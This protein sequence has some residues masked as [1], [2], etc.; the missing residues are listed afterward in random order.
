MKKIVVKKSV[1]EFVEFILKYGSLDNRFS[2]NARAIEGV[3]AHQKLQKSNLEIYKDYEKEVYLK[4]EIEMDVCSI[5]IEG[6]AD[7]IIVEGNETIIE[8]IKST[9]TPLIEIDEDYNPIHWAQGKVYA[10]MVAKDKKLETI[11][12]QL[13]YYNLDNDDVKTIRKKFQV[14]KLNDFVM[15]LALEY[16]K[17]AKVEYEHKKQ[18]N[19]KIE[20]INFPFP[21][22]RKG[23]LN[24]ARA[25]F[26]TIKE[27]KK[28]FAQAPTGIGKTI[29]TI[30]PAVKAIG[31]GYGERIFYL[32]AKGINRTVAESTFNKLIENGLKFRYITLTAKDKICLNDKVSCNPDDCPYAK[33]YFSKEKDVIFEIINEEL[34]I[35]REILILYGQKYEIC[36]FELSLG[37]ILWC[38]AVICDYN[39]IFDPKVYLRRVLDTSSVDNII[40]ID[41][42][43]NLIDRARMMYSAS[44]SKEQFLNMRKKSRGKLPKVYKWVNKINELFVEFRKN[45]EYEGIE[46][47]YDKKYPEELMPLLR[48]LL[49][50]CSEVLTTNKDLNFYEELLELYFNINSFLGISDL[51]GDE[52]VTYIKKENEDIVISLFCVDP[53]EKLKN[54]MNLCRATI[55]FSA[56]LSPI[57]YYIKLLGGNEDDY[58]LRLESP[59]PKEN[60]SVEIFAAN[61]R[62]N[63]REKTIPLICDKISKFIA[64]EFGNYMVFFPSYE[65]MEK[66]YSY[67]SVN[68]NIE[69]IVI[70]DRNMTEK[71]REVFLDK[72]YNDSG[73]IGFCV[74]GGIFS[75]GID[76]PGDKLIGAIIIGVGYPKISIENEIISKYFGNI[77]DK[78]SY[79]YPG[80]NKI[81]QAA[82][83]V[84][85]TEDDK[86]RVLLID[87]R[88]LN[89]TYSS[90]LPK[91]WRK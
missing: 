29:S 83:R 37:L 76:L 39:Y 42:V 72:F 85:R 35:S 90:L 61:T 45:I 5:F 56:T 18:R 36:P 11:S 24:L 87:D 1:R 23:Q 19:S 6:R 16:E 9:Y 51:Y 91:D 75:E 52:Y 88:Y 44:L 63:Y 73:Q 8:E 86:G 41:E 31:E 20:A 57:E 79:I 27:R 60:L 12:I 78:Y 68:Y 64:S 40:L 38:D 49:I 48:S 59:F 3:R 80:I 21:N 15:N 32:T 71:D 50:E 34:H 13:S 46:Y 55:L 33:D 70:Q 67:F 47:Y 54:T 53:S 4:T 77:G 26:G 84:I 22:Y 17:Y 2:N 69:K 7:G 89:Y 62:Y 82:G 10:Y 14:D 74:L 43:H 81:M 65:Y 66:I 30:F 28:L 25:V 58:R